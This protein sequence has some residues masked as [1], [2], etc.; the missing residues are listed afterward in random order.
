[1][2]AELLAGEPLFV[3]VDTD[4]DMLME[5]LH[6]RHEI[7]SMEL[8]AI[9]GLPEDLSQ[10]ASEMLL[11]LLCF[12]EDDRLTA[13]DAIRQQL[14]CPRRR[15]RLF[16]SCCRS[17]VPCCPGGRVLC[18]R[19]CRAPSAVIGAILQPSVTILLQ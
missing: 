2:M 9:R 5:V 8:Q 19:R 13:A 3:H 12:D 15:G 1:V 18:C 10:A 11:G 14:V 7:E 4:D 16:L 6:L 17:R